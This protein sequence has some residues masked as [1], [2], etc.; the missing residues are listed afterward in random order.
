MPSPA[1]L[2][3]TQSRARSSI[4]QPPQPRSSRRPNLSWSGPI[5]SLLHD[6]KFPSLAPL[7]RD[8]NSLPH[9]PSPPIASFSTREAHISP[10]YLDRSPLSSRTNIYGIPS[11]ATTGFP[12]NSKHGDSVRSKRRSRTYSAAGHA[13]SASSTKSHPEFGLPVPLSSHGNLQ[14]SS[15]RHRRSLS[16]QFSLPQLVSYSLLSPTTSQKDSSKT[17]NGH[18]HSRSSSFSLASPINS[19]RSSMRSP[20]DA[21]AFDQ[22]PRGEFRKARC[23]RFVIPATVHSYLSTPPFRISIKRLPPPNI[24]DYYYPYLSMSA[25]QPTVSFLLITTPNL[26]WS[27]R[28][29]A[30]QHTSFPSSTYH[31]GPLPYLSVH[32]VLIGIYMALREPI[33]LEE[34]DSLASNKELRQEILAA[35]R[36]RT[37]QETRGLPN[38][39]ETMRRVD[40]LAERTIFEGLQ[41]SEQGEG[42][43]SLKLGWKKQRNSPSLS[44]LLPAILH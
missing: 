39:Q 37:T 38:V 14:P 42:V 3:P 18:S 26:P 31:T 20:H 1:G 35:Y 19:R 41:P 30:Q 4:T 33:T 17:S 11:Y 10:S 29:R 44:F 9:P 34:Y 43:W 12:K 40:W 27:I 25:T 2:N 36:K 28:L 8:Q 32:D 5:S 6:L 21:I 22:D 24:A 23:V 16:D 7:N 13:M 15:L